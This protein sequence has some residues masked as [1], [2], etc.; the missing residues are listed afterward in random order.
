MPS[1]T[2]LSLLALLTP[3]IPSASAAS[4][5]YRQTTSPPIA[6]VPTYPNQ[7]FTSV[8]FKPPVFTID[9]TDAPL[10][11]GLIFITPAQ[12]GKV[13]ARRPA[14]VGPIIA[15]D[16]GTLIWNGPTRGYATN[17]RVHTY[18]NKSVISYWKGVANRFGTGYG[19]VT[20]LDNTYTPVA[21]ICPKVNIV[22]P[23]NFKFPCY[24]DL[25]EGLITD[26]DSMLI[27]MVNV[28]TTDLRPVGGPEVGWVLDS[29]FFE[30]DIATN[31]V[32]F[33]WS[34]LQAG[35]PINS[36]HQ[37]LNDFGLNQ[38][39]PF[40]WVHLNSIRRLPDGTYLANS[41]NTWST[42][43]VNAEGKVDWTINGDTGGD[44]T[45]ADDVHYVSE[46][47]QNWT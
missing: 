9:K 20:I 16:D 39:V 13:T 46:L 7:N 1:R 4:L 30:V 17:L 5:R 38:S 6:S 3:F 8:A 26:R 25:H 10:A 22:T 42:Y 43:R 2:A 14:Q 12:P 31:D 11:D 40:D 27:V 41:R 45:L 23:N 47:L 21:T 37:P 24:V 15:T 28:T 33:S 18:Q 32:L 44:F 19:N 29:M 34:P 36:T 35:V